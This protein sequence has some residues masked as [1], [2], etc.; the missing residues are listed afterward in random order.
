M[1]GN[2]SVRLLKLRTQYVPKGVFQIAPIFIEKEKGAIVEDVD[3]NEYIDFCAGISTLSIGHCNDNVVAVIREQTEKHLHSCFHVLMYESYVKLAQKL[4]ETTPGDFP[5]Q[6]LLANSGTEAVENAVK[7]AK[8]CTDRRGI[9]AFE[10]AFHRRT[11]MAIA[12]TSQVKYYK[13]G[14]G[15]FDSSI[16]RF[17]PPALL[18]GKKHSILLAKLTHVLHWR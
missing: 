17:P 3:G 7:I 12:L 15:P 13:Y 6:V 11:S 14:F 18:S 16:Q 2:K 5:K 9:I 1:P 10:Y 8:R 4:A